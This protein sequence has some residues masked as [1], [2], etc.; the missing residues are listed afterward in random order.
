MFEDLQAKLKKY[1]SRKPQLKRDDTET[2]MSFLPLLLSAVIFVVAVVL[3][4]KM[5]FDEE[6]KLPKLSPQDEAKLQ[7]RLKEIDDSEQYALVATTN[8][9]YSCLH[10]G[11]TTCY[12][13]IGEVWKY[14]VTSK[15]E[16]G[17]YTAAF[18]I[19]NK[20]F[21]IVQFKGNYSEC[22]KQEQI[23]L[24]NYPNLPE[25]LARPPTERL[26]RPPYNAIMR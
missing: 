2:R 15:G 18:L 4:L 5:T 10:N 3:F 24:F 13:K 20:V 9:W 22:L 21:Y 1:G 25:N 19:K 26:P 11:R 7:K 8:G 14:G 23:R 6:S 16:F 12:L 17:R